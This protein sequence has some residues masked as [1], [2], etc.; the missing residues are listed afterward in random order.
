M[1][2]KCA[3]RVQE[4]L[5]KYDGFNLFLILQDCKLGQVFTS[6][7]KRVYSVTLQHIDFE[8]EMATEVYFVTRRQSLQPHLCKERLKAGRA[9]ERVTLCHS[10]IIFLDSLKTSPRLLYRYREL[11]K[12]PDCANNIKPVVSKVRQKNSIMGPSCPKSTLT[13]GLFGSSRHYFGKG[14]TILLVTHTG[15]TPHGFQVHILM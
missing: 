5:P 4:P 9:N 11:N 3:V 15:D 8:Y 13:P 1:Q 6:S 12:E 14:H 2:K 10:L 7:E